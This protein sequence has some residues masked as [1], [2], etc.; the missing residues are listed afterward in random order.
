MG[1][2]ISSQLKKSYTEV[3]MTELSKSGSVFPLFPICFVYHILLYQIIP[4]AVWFVLIFLR[5]LHS[6]GED[7]GHT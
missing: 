7:L 1:M 2:C 5:V 4:H 6:M 3:R